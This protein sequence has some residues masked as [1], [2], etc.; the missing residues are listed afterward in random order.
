M[1]L[2][3]VILASLLVAFLIAQNYVLYSFPITLTYVI[4][5]FITRKTNKLSLLSVLVFVTVKNLIYTAMPQ[6]IIADIIGLFG[7][8]LISKINNRYVRYTIIPI[9]II[10]HIA[11]MDL[12]MALLPGAGLEIVVA[13]LISGGFISY[14]YAPLS[15]IIIV[16]FDGLEVLTDLTLE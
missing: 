15:I 12:S 13:G 9:M 3:E 7:F 2:K 8:V 4:I 10:L 14:I 16:M 6:T 1:K 11:I 5:Y